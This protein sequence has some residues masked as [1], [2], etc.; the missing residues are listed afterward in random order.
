[1][2]KSLLALL[3]LFTLLVPQFPSYHSF[4]TLLFFSYHLLPNYRSM[5]RLIFALTFAVLLIVILIL[6]PKAHAECVPIYGG[7]QSCT[8]PRLSIIKTVFNPS[9][10]SYVHDLGTNDTRFRSGDKVSFK[11]TV[12]NTGSGKATHVVITDFLPSTLLAVAPNPDSMTGP[13]GATI[14]IQSNDL[15]PSQSATFIV[16]GQVSSS[17]PKTIVCNSNQAQVK[18]SEN[19]DIATDFSQFCVEQA[20]TPTT[21][22]INL[23]PTPVATVAP[24]IFPSAPTTTLPPTGPEALPLFALIPTGLTGVLLRKL[25]KRMKKIS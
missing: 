4:T 20:V 17:L 22:L 12:T 5:K 10:N 9:S 1:M 11:I 16:V 8:N 7:G 18:S 13:S 15:N 25:A 19:A 23:T 21:G 14:T 2:K 24:T 3:S 6:I